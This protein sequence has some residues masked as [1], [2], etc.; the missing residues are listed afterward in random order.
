MASA[1][2]DERTRLWTFIVYPESAPANWRDVIDELHVAWA[3]SPLHEFDVNP[4]GEVKKA[5]YHVMLSFEGNK[6]YSQVTEITESINATIPQ[7]VASARGM[8]RYMAHLDNAEKYQYDKSQIVGHGGFDVADHLKPTSSNRYLCI[9]EMID[10]IVTEDICEFAEFMVY[11]MENRYDDW[12]ELLC[13]NSALVISAV[14]K[15]NRHRP[16][17]SNVG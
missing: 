17:S 14:I 5:H 9:K 2:K 12:F 15:S 1:K 6:S 8:V 4:T 10:F 3:E 11:A 13:D 7:K 16:R